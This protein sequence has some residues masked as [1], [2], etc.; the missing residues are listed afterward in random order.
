MLQDPH[1][2]SEQLERLRDDLADFTSSDRSLAAVY[3]DALLE[4][5]AS[6]TA[7]EVRDAVTGT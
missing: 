1:A 2:V 4:E 7:T 5:R 6:S 3:R